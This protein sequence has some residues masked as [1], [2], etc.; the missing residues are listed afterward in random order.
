[1]GERLQGAQSQKLTV[2]NKNTRKGSR[3]GG[4]SGRR[5]RSLTPWWF[6]WGGSAAGVGGRRQEGAAGYTVWC[7]RQEGAAVGEGVEGSP[8]F[9]WRGEGGSAP[10]KHSG[11]GVMPSPPLNALSFPPLNQ[12]PYSAPS[13][14]PQPLSHLGS[15]STFSASTD[16]PSASPLYGH[17]QLPL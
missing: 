6:W 1:M 3:W 12:H 2:P 5:R 15:H 14:P 9:F 7:G 8:C 10:L 4:I 13:V 11:Q 17:R 16:T